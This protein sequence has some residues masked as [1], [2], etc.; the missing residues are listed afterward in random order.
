MTGLKPK[1]RASRPRSPKE[2]INHRR[3]LTSPGPS[4][5]SRCSTTLDATPQLDGSV[6]STAAKARRYRRALAIVSVISSALATRLT[7]PTEGPA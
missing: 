1:S 4:L 3:D 5:G 7:R 6:L 2:C